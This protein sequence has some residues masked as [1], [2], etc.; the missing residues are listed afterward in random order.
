MLTD[1]VVADVV[2]GAVVFPGRRKSLNR[3]SDYWMMASVS[4]YQANQ[5]GIIQNSGLPVKYE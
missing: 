2:L 3:V 4:D 5:V 1:R